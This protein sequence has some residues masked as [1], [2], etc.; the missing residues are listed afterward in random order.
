MP[1]L[2]AYGPG[3]GEV[4]WPGPQL[5]VSLSFQLSS[6]FQPPLFFE[7]VCHEG[8]NIAS[9]ASGESDVTEERVPFQFFNY[10]RYPVVPADSQVVTLRNIVGEHDP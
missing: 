9:L 8:C 5:R 1:C 6:F 7:Q 2:Q 4:N 10:S 3:Q